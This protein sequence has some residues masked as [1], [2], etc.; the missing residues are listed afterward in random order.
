M[1]KNKF[2]FRM[3]TESLTLNFEFHNPIEIFHHLKLQ[4]VNQSGRLEEFSF[5]C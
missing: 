2:D 3:K 4:A 5:N 1:I